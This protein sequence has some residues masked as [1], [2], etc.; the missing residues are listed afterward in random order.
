MEDANFYVYAWLRE[1]GEPFYIGKGFGKRAEA[2][3]RNKFVRNIFAKMQRDGNESSIVYLHEGLNE[4]RAFELEKQEIAKWGRRDI[5]TGCLANLTDGGE[6]AC[7]LVLSA[8]SR[9]LISDRSVKQWQDSSFRDS[10]SKSAMKQ[11]QDPKHREAM[12]DARRK[13]WGDPE[14]RKRALSHLQSPEKRASLSIK[15]KKR[16][17]EPAYRA[18]NSEKNAENKRREGPR[19]DNK[20]GYKGVAARGNNWRAKVASYWLGNF[21]TPEAAARAYDEKAKELW[22]GDCY[23]NFP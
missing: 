16:W 18:I 20:T 3:R 19:K 15:S 2:L 7:G 5:G 12:A 6:G 22:G 9:K 11:W 23:L 10:Q 4:E 17:R 1:T 21:A 13:C 14:Y 8:A